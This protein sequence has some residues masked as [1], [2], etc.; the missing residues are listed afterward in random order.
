MFRTRAERLAE[1]LEGVPELPEGSDQVSAI[2]RLRGERLQA[3]VALK[4]GVT[5]AALSRLENGERSLSP[6]MAR[7]I[8]PALD[9]EATELLAAE[10][11]M[12]LHGAAVK[13]QLDPRRLLTA[14]EDLAWTLPEGEEVSDDI[15]EQ[16]LGVLKK[17]VKTY[18]ANVA[19][20]T[21]KSKGTK[22]STRDG[23]GRRKRVALKTGEKEPEGPRRDPSGR[24]VNK[25]NAPQGG[26]L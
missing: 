6:E 16:L 19:A 13:G 1:L 20:V 24:R 25:P 8:A 22:D 9:V 17:A 7:K 10:W 2:K 14:V 23:V 15:V 21:T 26:G 5:Q 11:V 18:D 12:R 4:A 3:E